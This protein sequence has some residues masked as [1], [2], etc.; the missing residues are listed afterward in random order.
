[1]FFSKVGIIRKSRRFGGFIDLPE[2]PINPVVSEIEATSALITWNNL[3][4]VF[5]EAPINPSVQQIEASSALIQWQI[6]GDNI[7]IPTNPTV[8]N[9]EE[10][11][12]LIQW[13]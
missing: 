9:I 1:M 3:D 4:E 7:I 12:A 11:Q 8:S 2:T 13:Q 10:T 5:I 6:V